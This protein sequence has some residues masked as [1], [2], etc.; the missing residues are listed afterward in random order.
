MTLDTVTPTYRHSGELSDIKV[1]VDGQDFHL[2]KF[3]LFVRSNFFKNHSSRDVTLDK[4]PGGAGVFGTVA[5]FCYNK[6]VQVT[7]DNVVEVR[8]AAEY[9]EMTGGGQQGGTCCRGGLATLADN[10][11]FE[12]LY[13]A[14]SKRDVHVPLTLLERAAR[15]PDLAD[16]SGVAEKLLESLVHGLASQSACRPHEVPVP[17]FDHRGRSYSS[18]SSRNHSLLSKRQQETLNHLPLSWANQLVRDGARSGVDHAQL[19]SIVQSYIDHKSGWAQSKHNDGHAPSAES[20]PDNLISIASSIL[21]AEAKLA[22]LTTEDDG[23][24]PA[25]NLVAIAAE[26]KGKLS[27]RVEKSK[28]LRVI[29]FGNKFIK[30]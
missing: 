10:V 25:A 9:L 7:F 23:P 16:K 24:K 19:A 2:H 12:Y 15:H 8:A 18:G 28:R 13:D 27:K 20:K 5:D 4:F 22:N 21:K 14:K 1:A 17:I 6:D 26:I 29:D 11:L 30:N 3:P